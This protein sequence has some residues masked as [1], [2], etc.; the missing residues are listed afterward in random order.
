MNPLPARR[1]VRARPRIRLSGAL[2]FR[3]HALAFCVHRSAPAATIGPPR[4][5]RRPRVLAAFTRRA[6]ELRAPDR[7]AAPR[8]LL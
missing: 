1:Y 2:A 3:R 7:R 6:L 8:A 4:P 5:L